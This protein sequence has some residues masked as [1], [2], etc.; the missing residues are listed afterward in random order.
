[1]LVVGHKEPFAKAGFTVQV[2]EVQRPAYDTL[3]FLLGII[4][5]EQLKEI[6]L[7]YCIDSSRFQAC[8]TK[9][10]GIYDDGCGCEVV[11]RLT[12]FFF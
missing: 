12:F 1:M 11:Y 10:T 8:K 3:R 5:P 7:P 6:T 2:M 4:D 9:H